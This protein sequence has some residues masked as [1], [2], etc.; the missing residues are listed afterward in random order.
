[1]RPAVPADAP[2]AAALLR[3]A[4]ARHSA[5]L[6][7]LAAMTDEDFMIALQTGSEFL[8]AEHDGAV[9]GTVR[10][11]AVEGTG[12][13]DALASIR[14]GA[15]HALVRAVEHWAQDHGFRT[16]RAS[17]PETGILPDRFARWGYFGVMREGGLLVVERRLPLLT[18]REQRREDA[19]AIAAITGG[20]PWPFTRGHLPGWFVLA[21]GERVTGTV[22]TD[23]LGGGAARITE[24]LLLDEYGD[25]GLEVWMIERATE[26]ASRRGFH[27]VEVLASP[28]LLPLRRDLEDRQWDYDG[29]GPNAR[30]QKRFGPAPGEAEEEW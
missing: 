25:R 8:V 1:V 14:F 3:H 23:D 9:V 4:F 6:P 12:W 28:T 21:D 16:M 11:W 27:T 10:R 29:P 24:P 5:M 15:G 7:T 17:V 2:A 13:F 26:D 30:F 18:V 20:D 19:E 22:S